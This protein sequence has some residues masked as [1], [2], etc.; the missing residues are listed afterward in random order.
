MKKIIMSILLVGLVL[1]SSGCASY[2]SYKSSQRELMGKR[3]AAS[4][5][6]AAIKAYANGDSVGIG[7]NVLAIESIKEHP[8]RQLGA[9]VLDVGLLYAAN[10]GI[11]SVNDNK[12]NSASGDT[13][14]Q[15]D[16]SGSDNLVTVFTD[17]N[18]TTTTSTT[19]TDNS[20]PVT[21]TDTDTDY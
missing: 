3:V 6:D 11:K 2:L 5:N 15:V 13:S 7:V 18:D 9:A 19:D 10:E 14:V 4:G 20:A 12:N 8:W 17:A 1:T 21:S 16:V